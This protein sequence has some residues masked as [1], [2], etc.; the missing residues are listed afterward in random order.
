V[1]AVDSLQV[2]RAGE[3]GVKCPLKRGSTN[4]HGELKMMQWQ[5][6]TKATN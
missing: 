5:E 4:L 2:Q 3:E 1:R 6:Y